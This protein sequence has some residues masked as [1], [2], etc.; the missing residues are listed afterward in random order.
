MNAPHFIKVFGYMY[1]LH[2][3]NFKAYFK[4]MKK[5]ICEEIERNSVHWVGHATVVINLDGK[6]IVTDPVTSLSLGH[7]KR[8]IKP[9]MKI[10]KVHMDYILLSHGHMDHLDYNTLRKINKD[11]IVLCPKYY[12]ATLKLLGYKNIIQLGPG[13]KYKDEHISIEAIEANHDGRR[14]YIGND[15]KSNAYAIQGKEKRI[16][17]A[18]DTAYT[19]AFNKIKADLALMPVGCYTPDEFRKMHCSPQESYN[20]FKSMDVSVMIPIHYKTY[21]LSQDDEEATNKILLELSNKDSAVKVIDI[22]ETFKF[23]DGS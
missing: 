23:G 15:I 14:F 17:F 20:M 13:D 3:R 12:K 7:L 1:Q 16:F 21:I 5:S 2:K 11:A 22:G 9:S 8:L 18:G 6:L 4:P 10:S 19:D